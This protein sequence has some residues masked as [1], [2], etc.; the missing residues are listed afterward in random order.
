MMKSILF[1][2][3][4]DIT[5]ED[6]IVFPDYGNVEIQAEGEY[7]KLEHVGKITISKSEKS[8]KIL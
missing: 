2:I 8:I 5:T 1:R 4:A 6:T 3:P 7:K